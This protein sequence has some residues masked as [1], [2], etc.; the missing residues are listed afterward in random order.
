MKKQAYY[1]R[2]GNDYTKCET[3]S[4]AKAEFTLAAVELYNYGQRLEGALYKVLPLGAKN[5]YPGYLL[6]VGK[7]GGTKLERT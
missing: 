7:A 5:E 6:S 4:K 2:I 1:L 3:L